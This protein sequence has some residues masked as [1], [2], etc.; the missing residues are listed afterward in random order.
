M[1]S[2]KANLL[3]SQPR[4]VPKNA[5]DS[6][7]EKKNENHN[8]NQDKDAIPPAV[9]SVEKEYAYKFVPS[10]SSVSTKKSKSS[11]GWSLLM[12]GLLAAG[13]FG[14]WY[15]AS[16]ANENPSW[17]YQSSIKAPYVI[18]PSG[19]KLAYNEY[20]NPLGKQVV[21]VF[22]DYL[23][24]R[25][26]LEGLGLAEALKE[27]RWANV[28]VVVLD[29]P[30]YGQ[31]DKQRHRRLNDWHEDVMR[32]VNAMGIES[33]SVIGIGAGGLYAL[34]CAEMIPSANPGR[35]INVALLGSEAP[36]LDP[37]GMTIPTTQRDQNREAMIQDLL[38]GQSTLGSL[39]LRLANVILYSSN[40]PNFV[41]EM[42]YGG[43]T[44]M[45]EAR[46]DAYKAMVFGVREAWSQGFHAIKNE[47]AATKDRTANAAIGY[48]HIHLAK[49]ACIEMWHGDKDQLVPLPMAQHLAKSIPR[50][51]LHICRG[52]GHLSTIVNNWSSALEFVTT[53]PPAELEEIKDNTKATNPAH[54]EE[55]VPVNK[56]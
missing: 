49:G 31:S 3:Y 46:P 26:E 19:R 47:L 15:I 32:V 18:T 10:S 34:S 30:G 16:E 33:F 29:R 4:P 40:S 1:S 54:L 12:Y 53:P 2:S 44:K 52:Q 8:E 25:T 5:N 42:M 13:A 48:S 17:W 43:D 9:A 27:K 39:C 36:R 24:G 28:R 11:H 14:L 50:A 22:H 23:A 37:F 20:G 45:L 51:K 7:H 38:S 35:L 41:F 21:L 55:K 6:K 56:A